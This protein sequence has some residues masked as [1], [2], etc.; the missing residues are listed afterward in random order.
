LKGDELSFSFLT[1]ILQL[2]FLECILSID[3]AAIMGAMVA[4]LPNDQP[5]PWPARLRRALGWIDRLL[6]PQR[7]AALKVGL[8]GAYAGRIVMLAL[9]SLIIERPWVQVLGALYLLYL[10]ISHFV[11]G[12]QSGRENA[13][14]RQARLRRKG[15][16]SVV[17]ALNL[18]DMAFSLDNVV[19]AVA[20]SKELW[21]VIVGV[22]IGIL[23]IRFGATIF[24]RLMEWEPALE[25]AAYLLLVAIGV[26][27]LLEQWLHFEI[28]YLVKFVISMSIL[29]LTVLGARARA[30][31]IARTSKVEHDAR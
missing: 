24:S 4:H 7:E 23:I 8:F 13:Q 15:F 30:S 11:E 28:H 14:Q 18:A 10:A 5:T 17:L 20:L 29:A 6:G 22:G 12:Y 1:I 3:N 31:Y 25:H 21:I 9:A 16:W 26:E 27:I 19:A 2:V